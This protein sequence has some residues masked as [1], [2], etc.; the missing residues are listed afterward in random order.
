MSHCVTLLLL[1]A[2]LQ[3]HELQAA[4]M[5]QVHDWTLRDAEDEAEPEYAS[6]DA[7]ESAHSWLQYTRDG[8]VVQ[9]AT[10]EDVDRLEEYLRTRPDIFTAGPNSHLESYVPEQMEDG[11][12]KVDEVKRVNR[13]PSPVR[14]EDSVPTAG[15]LLD[16]VDSTNF[17]PEYAI[18]ILENGCTAF[19]IGPCHALTTAHCVYNSTT[20]E[21]VDDLN[22]WRG[23]KGD[24]Y[25]DQMTW[26]SVIVPRNYTAS[27][28]SESNWA[29]IIYDRHTL[30]GVWLKMGFSENI[31]NIPYTIYGYL[32]SKP[33]GTMYSTVC[34]SRTEEPENENILSVQC[35]SDECFDGG[36]LLRGYNFKRSKMPVVYGVS[37]SSCD[38]YSF[39]HNS[40]V[41][42]PDLFWSLCYFM[43]ENGFDARCA[44]KSA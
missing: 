18:G 6:G 42:Q 12:N 31:Y 14:Q 7:S 21:F 4:R 16:E 39:S 29:L 22:M 27:P 28:S 1:I 9:S 32:S 44:I 41:F 43:S 17:Y 10:V 5:D 38:S 19:L 37:L 40:L 15:T 36:P 34:R 11:P 2:G 24:I 25:L 3:L 20:D 8:S 35:G 13:R 33:F 23:R 30:S 26:T